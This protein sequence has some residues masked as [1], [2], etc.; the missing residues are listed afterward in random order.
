MFGF[1]RQGKR[2]HSNRSLHA[3]SSSLHNEE[4]SSTQRQLSESR[5]ALKDGEDK[6]LSL[7]RNRDVD[8]RRLWKMQET[9]SKVE[10]ERDKE[11]SLLRLDK[12][13][14]EAQ[15]ETEREG[16]LRLEKELRDESNLSEYAALVEE[17]ISSPD[18]HH[19]PNGISSR[20]DSNGSGAAGGGSGSE[21]KI[22]RLKHHLTRALRRMEIIAGRVASV[23]ESCD[24]LSKK[25]R[26][27]YARDLEVKCKDQI[28]VMN[29]LAV[30]R[31][32]KTDLEEQK[33]MEMDGHEKAIRVLEER[34][35]ESERRRKGA[36]E[37]AMKLLEE[38]GNGNNGNRE[39]PNDVVSPSQQR[40]ITEQGQNVDAPQSIP[41]SFRSGDG[42]GGDLERE[43]QELLRSKDEMEERFRG[44]A[45]DRDRM[46]A[47]LEEENYVKDRLIRKLQRAGVD[48][49]GSGSL[50]SSSGSG[51]SSHSG[52]GGA[53]T[54]G[55]GS[56]SKHGQV[57]DDGDA[58]SLADVRSSQST[59]SASASGMARTPAAG[60]MNPLDA[61]LMGMSF[62]V[63]PS[64]Q[65]NE[66]PENDVDEKL[67]VIAANADESDDIFAE[68]EEQ[69]KR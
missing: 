32:E 49:D 67:P 59:A 17:V 23:K 20:R 21:E 26:E 24:A 68:S 58:T 33:R 2:E 10:A 31:L 51:L 6:I 48:L 56:G 52:V 55:G 29:Q 60:W 7:E 35:E 41:S 12:R 15:L 46:I 9:L 54:D 25:M 22:H 16:A 65:I 11:Y 38:K 19:A 5:A 8:T 69:I 1:G 4:L 13:R 14:L 47:W 28:E 34:L 63:I 44:E 18:P 36:E 61:S 62:S 66:E 30:H 57:G 27:E 53:G 37:A 39:N 42:E 43:L 45:K 50:G 40:R 3:S 64:A